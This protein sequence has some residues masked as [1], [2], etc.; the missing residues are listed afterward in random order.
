MNSDWLNVK[1]RMS[2]SVDYLLLSLEKINKLFL[3]AQNNIY[4]LI[5][6]VSIALQSE[7]GFLL[8]PKLKI[9]NHESG[10]RLT[11]CIIRRLT[12]NQS[13]RTNLF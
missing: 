8:L 4:V 3:P 12:I 10:Q 1:L 6:I 9:V 7:I 13:E 11:T 2:A 5:K